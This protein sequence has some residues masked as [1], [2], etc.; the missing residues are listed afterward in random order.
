ML[1]LSSA[2]IGKYREITNY[3]GN[4]TV[5]SIYENPNKRDKILRLSG[6]D[7]TPIIVKI[8]GDK[9]PFNNEKAAL[10]AFELD[11]SVIALHGVVESEQAYCLFLA[12]GGNDFTTFMPVEPVIETLED[13]ANYKKNKLNFFIQDIKNL[14]KPVIVLIKKMAADKTVHGDIKPGNFLYQ[15]DEETNELKTVAIDL[16]SSYKLIGGELK[17]F[18]GSLHDETKHFSAP[19]YRAPENTV[20]TYASDVW[21]AGLLGL[22]LLIGQHFFENQSEETIKTQELRAYQVEADKTIDDAAKGFLNYLSPRIAHHLNQEV[23]DELLHITEHD[24]QSHRSFLQL[25]TVITQMLQI[26]PEK[27]ITAAQA[28]DA[29]FFK[30]M[31]EAD[32]TSDTIFASSAYSG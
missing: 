22:S 18:D 25:V 30:P 27:R 29:A 20:P 28:S 26:N 4:I 5:D 12:D 32:P 17:S 15:E 23:E 21:A 10:K 16:E 7:I 8:F 13:K 2:V 1:K 3:K 11:S 24:I 31:P 9:A 14:F 6:E 19:S